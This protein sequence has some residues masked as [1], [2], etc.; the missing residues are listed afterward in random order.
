PRLP[1]AA[2]GRGQ[3]EAGGDPRV[4]GGA[5]HRPRRAPRGGVRLVRLPGARPARLSGEAGPGDPRGDRQGHGRHHVPGEERVERRFDLPDARREHRAPHGDARGHVVVRGRGG[6]AR[7]AV[8][9]G[10]P[11]D[12]GPPAVARFRIPASPIAPP[13]PTSSAVIV[14][15]SRKPDWSSRFELPATAAPTTAIPSSPATRATAL[16]TPLAMPASF[17]CTSASTVAVSGATIID[18]PTENPSTG[19]SSSSQ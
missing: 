2:A 8:A 14:I 13:A 9:G 11:A 4:H 15:A 12:G 7:T 6:S 3:G 18:S 19:G 5:R 10:G 17:S 1:V 16:L